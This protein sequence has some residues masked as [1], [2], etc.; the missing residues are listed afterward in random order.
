MGKGRS[1][2]SGPRNFFIEVA[3][4]NSEIIYAGTRRYT[5]EPQLYK[6]IDGGTTWTGI[7]LGAEIS[8]I[9]DIDI[10]ADGTIWVCGTEN[11]PGDY[12]YI[13]IYNQRMVVLLGN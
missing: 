12:Q 4:H 2:K 5:N 6:S 13:R 8:I 11:L 10:A 3:P 1:S 9:Y 7:N